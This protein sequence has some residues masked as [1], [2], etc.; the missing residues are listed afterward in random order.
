M[1]KLTWANF[2]GAREDPDR[3]QHFLVF[4]IMD[5]L[6][7]G[8]FHR[9]KHLWDHWVSSFGSGWWILLR[10]TKTEEIQHY[11][12]LHPSSLIVPTT[13][14]KGKRKS[15]LHGASLLL[16]QAQ[17]STDCSLRSSG[18]QLTCSDLFSECNSTLLTQRPY[19]GEKT[20]LISAALLLLSCPHNTDFI[21]FYLHT[22]L[23]HH[24]VPDYPTPWGV[25]DSCCRFW[26]LRPLASQRWHQNITEKSKSCWQFY[27]I[28]VGRT[29]QLK[30]AS[31][32]DKHCFCL[33][34]ST[35][36]IDYS[37]VHCC[38]RVNIIQL[39]Q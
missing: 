16:K 4:S 18:I 14:C 39:I 28:L 37:L 15:I 26:S 21:G 17:G 13:H 6:L 25:G 23:A 19:L 36:S 10:E 11:K 35:H 20:A 29:Q 9:V 38:L 8:I 3:F 34:V 2:W 24:G 1:E 32:D 12:L 33:D 31:R 5:T 27:Q 7:P 22:D 30:A